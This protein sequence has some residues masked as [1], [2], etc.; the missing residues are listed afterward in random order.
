M[1]ALA[2]FM[3]S[4]TQEKD[5]IVKMGTI[6]STKDQSLAS[7]VS[8]QAKCKNKF[9]DLKQQR[10]K[11]KKHSDT[12]IS[13]STDEDSIS[14]RMKNKR[15]ITTC[16]YFKGSHH[17]IYFFINNMGIMTQLLVDNNIGVPD[18]ARRGEHKQEDGKP[19][20]YLC[21]WE[22]HIYCI[23]VSDINYDI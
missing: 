16:G 10:E 13:S 2:D 12:K 19:L 11:E 8:I 14:K 9:K 17:E 21:A 18:F 22:R 1:H 15:E 23:Y 4:L 3:E 20:N 6:K 7:G 5:K